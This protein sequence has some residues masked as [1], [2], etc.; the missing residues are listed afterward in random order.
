VCLNPPL[1]I[2]PLP[3]FF[4][5]ST[6]LSSQDDLAYEVQVHTSEEG[7]RESLDPGKEFPGEE[8]EG[9]GVHKWNTSLQT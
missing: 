3:T 7:Y 1:K 9:G 5:L 2:L 8:E 4:S 6:S